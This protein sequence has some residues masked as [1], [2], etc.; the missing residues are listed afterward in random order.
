MDPQ[1]W[2]SSAVASAKIIKVRF[3]L[4]A[5]TGL[6]RRDHVLHLGWVFVKYSTLQSES[7]QHDACLAVF[8]LVQNLEAF[9]CIEVILAVHL[10]H[11]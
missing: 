7:Q 4:N 9:G 11:Q 6:A 8:P 2:Q 10:R 1:A 3:I 5:P